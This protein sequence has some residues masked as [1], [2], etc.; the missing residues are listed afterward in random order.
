VTATQN[1]SNGSVNT[2]GGGGGA[3]APGLS[4]QRNGGNG[5]SGIVMVR[6]PL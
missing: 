3:S 5:G 4:V 2:G 6:W 1:G